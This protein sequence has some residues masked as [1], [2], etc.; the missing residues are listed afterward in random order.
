MHTRGLLGL[1][2]HWFICFSLVGSWLLLHKSCIWPSWWLCSL[3]AKRF[4]SFS[5]NSRL[6]LVNF[7]SYFGGLCGKN[8]LGIRLKNENCHK[9]KNVRFKL[10]YFTFISYCNL[11][12]VFCILFWLS[13]FFVRKCLK[14]NTLC[15]YRCKHLH[16]IISPFTSVDFAFF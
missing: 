4:F 7:S 11:H 9:H 1:S 5:V 8:A 2:L 15:A 14:S 6:D 10:G 12:W 13:K 3:H 16:F